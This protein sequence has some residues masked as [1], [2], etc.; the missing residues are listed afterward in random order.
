MP[1]GFKSHPKMETEWGR[2]KERCNKHFY[3][4][5][6][7]EV[8]M[9]ERQLF[10]TYTIT[11]TILGGRKDGVMIQPQVQLCQN[12]KQKHTAKLSFRQH[13]E[14]MPLVPLNTQKWKRMLHWSFHVSC[15]FIGSSNNENVKKISKHIARQC[16]MASM[17]GHAGFEPD[18]LNLL[19]WKG[20]D[21]K[22]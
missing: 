7:K 20:V 11:T 9:R 13:R 22:S 12:G 21:L 15:S 1:K 10:K 5:L 17:T 8:L 6:W 2:Q 16:C 19:F 14:Q 18:F 4:G 3:L